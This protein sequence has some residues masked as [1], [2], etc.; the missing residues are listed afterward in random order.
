MYLRGRQTPFHSSFFHWRV[1]CQEESQM[2]MEAVKSGDKAPGATGYQSASQQH[3]GAHPICPISFQR[4]SG[5]TSHHVVCDGS[6]TNLSHLFCQLRF[7][8]FVF[9]YRYY[10]A[11]LIIFMSKRSQFSQFA[12]YWQQL[13]FVVI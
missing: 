4:D 5:K 6:H 12:I 9:A 7:S 11:K 13:F 2:K 1:L 10:R 3:A 8:N